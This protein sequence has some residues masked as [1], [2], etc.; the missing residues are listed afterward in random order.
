MR[1]LMYQTIILPSFFK[2]LK[3]YSK[4]YR[5]LKD[6]IIETLGHFRKDQ[7][8]HL[9]NNVY[10]I[11]LKTKDLPKGKSK[12]F[13]LIVLVVEVERYLVP[14]SLYFKGDRE[15]ITKKEINDY[16][17][18]ALFELRSQHLLN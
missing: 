6:A 9:G 5:H 8:I 14:I 17:A 7:Y 13:R 2:Q 4:K 12:S 16:L 1:P 18:L 11:R 3:L 15:N 10:K